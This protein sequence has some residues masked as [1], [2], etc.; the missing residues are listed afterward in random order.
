MSDPDPD[1]IQDALDEYERE[2][3]FARHVLPPVEDQYRLGFPRQTGDD[4]RWFRSANVIDLEKV[5]RLKLAG[6]LPDP[7]N[8]FNRTNQT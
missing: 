1:R 4:Y 7:G 3:E 8:I 5:R 6:R 2:H